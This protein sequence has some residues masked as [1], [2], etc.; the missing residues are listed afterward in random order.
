MKK[1]SCDVF[2]NFWMWKYYDYSIK[3]GNL[4][5]FVTSTI[6][7]ALP[8][9][10]LIGTYYKA[11]KRYEAFFNGVLLFLLSC[12]LF[13]TLAKALWLIEGGEGKDL[14]LLGYFF[15]EVSFNILS[16]IICVVILLSILYN[17]II[18]ALERKEGE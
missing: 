8:Y 6:I 4:K 18:E 1:V 11:G 12:V 17:G 9:F 3:N 2:F 7:F 5:V 13:P 16:I 15:K 14:F 10:Y